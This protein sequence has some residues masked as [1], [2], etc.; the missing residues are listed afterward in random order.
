MCSFTDVLD[1]FTDHSV[2]RTANTERPGG[3]AARMCEHRYINVV[4]E[5]EFYEFLL[6]P[7]KFNLTGFSERFPILKLDVLFGRNSHKTYLA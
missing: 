3:L 5:S 7:E 2:V 4:K 6:T 1:R